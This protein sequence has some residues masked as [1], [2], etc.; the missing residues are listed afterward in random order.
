M[1]RAVCSKFGDIFGEEDYAV[2]IINIFLA[3]SLEDAS[4]TNNLRI[5]R[6][7]ISDFIRSLND[8]YLNR[9]V[10]FRLF[11][12]ENEDIAM[13]NTR[14]QDEYNE[15]IKESDIFMVLFLKKVGA[16]T[17]EE[18]ETAYDHFREKG[19]PSILTFFRSE[20]EQ[21]YTE[22]VLAFMKKLDEMGHFFKI[23]E[24]IDALKLYLLMQIKVMNLDNSIEFRNGFA[25][26]GNEPI[27]SLESLPALL[28]NR[29]LKKLR[30]EYKLIE[31]EFLD[32]KARY[33]ANPEDDDGYLTAINRRKNAKHAMEQLE[34]LILKI[35]L[36]SM[37]EGMKGNLTP[38][39]RKAFALL[40]QGDCDTANQILDV[41]EIR[42]DYQHAVSLHQMTKERLELY[43]AEMLQKI[44]IMMMMPDDMNRFDKIELIYDEVVKWEQ[45]HNLNKIAMKRYL[46]YL[47]DIK[48]FSKAEELARKYLKWQELSE[49]VTDSINTAIYLAILLQKKG[50]R[51]E[52]GLLFEDSMNKI[53]ELTL[54]NGLLYSFTDQIMILYGLS[55]YAWYLV[56]NAKW[57]ELDEKLSFAQMEFYMVKLFEKNLDSDH[58]Y[59]LQSLHL[60]FL[61]ALGEAYSKR[62]QTD[63]AEA[64]F[65]KKL[66]FEKE[67]MGT[68]NTNHIL[69]K[70]SN[71]LYN[72][73]VVYEAKRSYEKAKNFYKEAIK[74]QTELAE[75]NP[76]HFNSLAIT[77]NNLGV[78]MELTDKLEKA[79]ECYLKAANSYLVI[80]QANIDEYF[81]RIVS[82]VCGN[83]D[84]L[85]D[86]I[87]VVK[88]DIAQIYIRTAILLE[89]SGDL[90][91]AKAVYS[92]ALL[93]YQEYQGYKE[94][95]IE[96][97]DKI[98]R[99]KKMD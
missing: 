5:D 76:A 24:H 48:K 85:S 29:N 51:E 62:R 25:Y 92:G 33:L 72:L 38:R 78:V 81:W 42:M 44:D 28:N 41:D 69:E 43:V 17:K 87:Y 55:N 63:K 14:K 31:Q 98:S 16:Y 61:G 54:K 95:I 47:M 68:Y 70:Y 27:L 91:K 93:I 15:H 20:N 36:Q 73:G 90:Q 60:N 50:E 53:Y 40:E 39:Q 32:V 59:K 12:C 35:T 75:N 67:L 84:S 11:R 9:S 96:L 57:E 2:K 13:V 23:Y 99:F 89:K 22:E 52:A 64:I 37:E 18:F 3:S 8:R 80:A 21:N 6:L 77:Y 58:L 1:Y 71:T 30:N 65:L 49:S 74:I 46:W 4:E 86:E 88:I 7:E 83:L 45:K 94:Q 10:Y 56:D 19:T 82:L 26:I 66:E 34:S 97:T 79:K